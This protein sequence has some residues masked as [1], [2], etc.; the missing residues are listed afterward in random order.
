[1]TKKDNDYCIISNGDH[2]TDR[3]TPG[4]SK[5]LRGL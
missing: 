2:Q 5:F 3:Q 1:M 4:L